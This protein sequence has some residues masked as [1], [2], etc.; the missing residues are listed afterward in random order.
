MFPLFIRFI[1]ILISGLVAGILVGIWLGYNPMTFSFS[2]YLEYQQGAIR[3]LNTIMPLL[4]LI[5]ILLTLT[6]AFLQKKNK[7]VYR[8]L[9][10]AGILLIIGGLV[11]KFGNQPINSTVMTWNNSIV[12][13]NWTELRNKWW[14]LHELR[15]VTI[16]FAFC[17][18]V[19]ATIRKD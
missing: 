5:S 15:T 12:P 4:G 13:D 16:L 8:T 10:I 1:N 3:S 19:W 14:S 6:S 18:I 11:T 9:L 17:L 2:T 7:I